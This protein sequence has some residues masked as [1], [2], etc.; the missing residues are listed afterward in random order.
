MRSEDDDEADIGG[1]PPPDP[2]LRSWRHPSELA[3]AAA[4]ANRPLTPPRSRSRALAPAVVSI[5]AIGLAATL[6]VGVGAL[7]S[8]FDDGSVDLEVESAVTTVASLGALVT[9]PG[10]GPSTTNRSGAGAD[11]GAAEG[12]AVTDQGGDVAAGT[13]GSTE[14]AQPADSTDDT[15]ADGSPAAGTEGAAGAASAEATG[16]REGDGEQ[17]D[18][19]G[20][21]Q[22]DGSYRAEQEIWGPAPGPMMKAGDGVFSTWS[23]TPR[24]LAS[25]TVVDGIIYTSASA[26]EGHTQLSILVDSLLA[27]ATVTG[28]DRYTDLA[29]IEVSDAD[30]ARILAEAD[31]VWEIP[32]EWASPTPGDEVAIQVP[33]APGTPRET[34]DGVVLSDDQP[35]A[36]PG[37]TTVY[38][39]LLTTVYRP[40]GASGG[41]LV[42]AEGD[43][44]GIVVN[45]T[46]YLASA[47]PIERAVS[48][49]QNLQRW[50]VPAPE[51]LG[52]RGVPLDRGGVEITAIMPDSPAE[53]AGLRTGHEIK[54]IDG[55]DVIDWAHLV[56]LIRRSGLDSTIEIEVGGLGRDQ[57]LE[58]TIGSRLDATEV[59]LQPTGG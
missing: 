32:L 29:T 52:V 34:T 2:S 51:W 33:E 49:G 7:T 50:Q 24:R 20:Q 55:T 36:L 16:P 44:L 40:D 9:P 3:S 11:E 26:I 1:G 45:S 58:A 46:A 25:I 13:A 19:G 8:S 48:V 27:P 5:V 10:H 42:S 41:A 38:G 31:S 21:A 28:I 43:L 59:A 12:G 15:G 47:V 22:A 56:H 4:A 14:T 57:V 53:A 54:A 37:S 23:T 17:A 39:S 6:I 18:T 35:A 30:L